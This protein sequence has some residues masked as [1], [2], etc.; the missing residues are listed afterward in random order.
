PLAPT[1]LPYPTLFRSKVS[2]SVRKFLQMGKLPET[3]ARGDVGKVEFAAGD[4]DL[5]A[6]LAEARHALQ[7]K[8]FAQGNEALLR[9][10]QGTAL[11]RGDVLVG[12]KAEGDEVAERAQ[13]AY[14]PARAERL[15][16]VFDDPEGFPAGDRIQ[17]VAI[18]RQ[19]GEI[20]GD[21]RAGRRRE[22]RFDLLQVDVP[23][24]RIDIDE[25]RARADLEHDIGGGDPGKGRGNYLVPGADARQPQADLERGRAGGKAAHGAPAAQPR[26]RRLE[27]LHLRPGGD[28]AGAQ[29]L[30]H[31][32]DRFLVD[33]RAGERQVI[34]HE[35][36][37][38]NTPR[39]MIPIPTSRIGVTASPSRY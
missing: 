34:G 36:A 17:A 25:H 16:G 6:V 10:N 7:A 33:R 3:E 13:G 21:Q 8:F 23:G 39:T 37:T 5:H 35:R 4:I 12:M 18:D 22:R 19:P 15:G 32:G 9:Q 26:Q 29:D 20:D 27:R 30:G 31:A 11:G 2:P 14:A 24:A 1:L 38:M 28:P